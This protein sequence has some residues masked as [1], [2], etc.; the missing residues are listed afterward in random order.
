MCDRYIFSMTDYSKGKLMIYICFR[1][2]KGI[3]MLRTGDLPI[4]HKKWGS[5]T[6]NQLSTKWI[7]SFILL[8]PDR[9]N[10]N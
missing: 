10:E 6:R 9:Q 7:N 2:G 1:R 5:S 4:K 3:K 8:V